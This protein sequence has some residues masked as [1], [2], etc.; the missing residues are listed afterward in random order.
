[1]SEIE[2]KKVDVKKHFKSYNAAA[3]ALGIS[4][5]AVHQWPARVPQGAAYKLQVITGG[6]LQVRP[7]M[8]PSQAGTRVPKQRRASVAQRA[9]A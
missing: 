1:V 6:I 3:K 2:M 8:Y 5:S 7:D 4:R 9:S